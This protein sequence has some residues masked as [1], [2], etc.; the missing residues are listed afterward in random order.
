MSREEGSRARFK[1]TEKFDAFRGEARKIKMESKLKAGYAKLT[2]LSG[3]LGKPPWCS[4][5]SCSLIAHRPVELH[6][7]NESG[8]CIG[9]MPRPLVTIDPDDPV[10][11]VHENDHWL[12]VHS[13]TGNHICLQVTIEDCEAFSSLLSAM[14][15]KG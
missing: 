12:C 5:V 11:E 2:I 10:D 8:F 9:K 4:H 13:A 6:Y 14:R 1:L 7:A 3:P 15:N